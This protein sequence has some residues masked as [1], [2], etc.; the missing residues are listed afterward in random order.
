MEKRTQLTVRD[1]KFTLERISPSLYCPN[2]KRQYAKK[3]HEDRVNRF[4]KTFY[5][6]WHSMTRHCP[7]VWGPSVILANDNTEYNHFA[8]LNILH[9]HISDLGRKKV[10]YHVLNFTFLKQVGRKANT[11]WLCSAQMYGETNVTLWLLHS[12]F[13]GKVDLHIYVYT[14]LLF[15][16]FYFLH[17]R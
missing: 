3:S 8:C 7:N 15:T 1:V 2:P 11:Q 16:P 4:Y 10:T 14:F 6:S 12:C 9:F 5:C 17:W 13:W